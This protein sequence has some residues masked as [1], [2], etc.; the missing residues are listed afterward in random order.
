MSGLVWSPQKTESL[1][2]QMALEVS[3][4]FHDNSVLIVTLIGEILTDFCK[5]NTDDALDANQR[6][7]KPEFLLLVSMAIIT[8]SAV[9]K[10]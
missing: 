8:S 5:H 2:G 1:E 7:G 3:I 9:K 4:T 6:P 10:I